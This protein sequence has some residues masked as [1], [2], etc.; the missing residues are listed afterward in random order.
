MTATF[1]LVYTY[2]ADTARREAARA[3]HRE[4]LSSGLP[5]GVTL[6]V[7]GAWVPGEAP[8]GLLI[9]RA[10]SKAAVQAVADNDPY[11]AAGVLT[12]TQIREWGAALGPV[13]AALSGQ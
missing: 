8:G 13:A 1:A 7:A 4:Y 9:F 10:E 3:A 6:L 2:S 5:E 12:D 11:A